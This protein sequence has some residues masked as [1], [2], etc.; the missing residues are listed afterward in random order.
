MYLLE[1][2]HFGF[3]CSARILMFKV[4]LFRIEDKINYI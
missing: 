4:L 1:Y 3:L 2:I